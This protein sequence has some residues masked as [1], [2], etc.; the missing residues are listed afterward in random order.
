MNGHVSFC[1]T[2]TNDFI[3][4]LFLFILLIFWGVGRKLEGSIMGIIFWVFSIC[5]LVFLLYFINMMILGQM[6]PWPGEPYDPGS[7][8]L[9]RLLLAYGQTVG[10]GRKATTKTKCAALILGPHCRYQGWC[11]I[12]E[13]K[14]E[15]KW[16]FAP[17]THWDLGMLTR[18]IQQLY[19]SK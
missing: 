10:R 6:S 7:W 12:H 16:A 15:S 3:A 11:W 9:D 17:F 13:I 2:M 4:F 18:S 5:K 14:A 8:L 1:F 19:Q